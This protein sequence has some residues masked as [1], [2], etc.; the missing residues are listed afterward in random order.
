M[1][2]QCLRSFLTLLFLSSAASAQTLPPITPGPTFTAPTTLPEPPAIWRE[3]TGVK[4][5][6]PLQTT[7]AL[8]Q[9]VH[10]RSHVPTFHTTRDGRIGIDFKTA[11]ITLLRPE[12]LGSYV[13]QIVNT[14]LTNNSYVM[15][16][17]QR[18]PFRIGE[19]ATTA[20]G[21][22][23]VEVQRDADHKSNLFSLPTG[24][25]GSLRH[26]TL[27]DPTSANPQA[28]EITNPQN[29]NGNDVYDL[30]IIGVF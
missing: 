25:V 12:Q 10:T 15:T 19:T 28:G 23:A 8:R 26:V 11:K 4:Y 1:K 29:S 18:R 5:L 22:N 6:F 27:F 17:K 16:N 9:A 20:M 3:V 30:N 7:D 2:P 24:W 13:R 14:D 21:S